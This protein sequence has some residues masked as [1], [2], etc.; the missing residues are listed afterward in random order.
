MKTIRFVQSLFVLSVI[1]LVG[2]GVAAENGDALWLQEVD[3]HVYAIVGPYGNR[4]PEN[5]GNNATFGF[6]VTEAGV[7]LID[8]G[9]SYQGAAAI[10]TFIQQVTDQPVKVVVNT[11]GQDHRW[12]GNGYFKE[13]GAHIIA[14]E[15][16]VEDQRSRLQDQRFMLSNLVGE[17]GMA[18][19]EPVYADE[20]FADKTDFTLGGTAFELQHVGPA[21]TPGD[22][23][24]WLPAQRVVFTGDVVYVGRL[25]GVMSHSSSRNWIDAFGS[26]AELKPRAVVPGHGPVTD[27]SRARADTLEY[28][29]FLRQT[30][31][32][33]MEAGGSITEIGT[34]D[35]SRFTY[36]EDY[37]ALKGRNAQQVYQE[38]EW[39]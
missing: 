23:L 35:Q 5:L 20:V 1:S 14:S 30:V 15:A 34:L 37:E 18:G 36:L 16:A 31:G 38:M 13:R 21:H 33:F 2:A 7:V 12:L 17:K 10:D 4:T 22:S 3:E 39:E 29:V 27:L 26:V 32:S 9:G 11:G 25:L 28:L 6:V 24:V 8:S 19:T